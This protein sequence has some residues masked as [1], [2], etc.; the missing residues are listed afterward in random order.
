MI[1]QIIEGSIVELHNRSSVRFVDAITTVFPHLQKHEMI[2]LL[3]GDILCRLEKQCDF[4]LDG[5]FATVRGGFIRTLLL[6]TQGVD[7]DI[8]DSFNSYPAHVKG[9]REFTHQILENVFDLKDIDVLLHRKIMDAQSYQET[10]RLLTESLITYGYSMTSTPNSFSNGQYKV[11]VSIICVD[12]KTNR[13]FF[14]L[15]CM[16]S[17]RQ[18]TLL[19]LNIGDYPSENQM[20]RDIRN[21]ADASK[22]DQ[23]A[24]GVL[25]KDQ[26][27]IMLDV[28]RAK[29]DDF[30]FH[31]FLDLEKKYGGYHVKT[32]PQ[33][34]GGLRGLSFASFLSPAFMP[35]W[36]TDRSFMSIVIRHW[37]DLKDPIPQ[38]HITRWISDHQ[39]ELEV[40][41]SHIVSD[42]ISL[43]TFNPAF[44]LWASYLDGYLQYLPIGKKISGL[45]ELFGVVYTVGKIRGIDVTRDQI[46]A[47]AFSQLLPNNRESLGSYL[48]VLDVIAA[49]KK[50]RLLPEETKVDMDTAV[51]LTDPLRYDE[52]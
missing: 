47:A 13:Y 3:A 6:D 18:K 22:I 26:D 17:H 36:K 43:L 11:D 34:I 42:A 2:P 48:G 49:M 39:E 20:T 25:K 7:Q 32:V 35:L 46:G 33:F 52:F 8:I 10:L 44:G 4:S 27:E 16:D 31:Y 37:G 40:R 30:L 38:Q 50:L 45:K 12:P 9:E 51:A 14:N 1:P 29:L 23:L 21:T 19:K 15:T 24:R 28:D 5:T 41:E